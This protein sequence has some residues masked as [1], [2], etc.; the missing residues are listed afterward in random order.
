MISFRILSLTALFFVIFAI[1]P[2]ISFCQIDSNNIRI[3][4][5]QM[6]EPGGGH[7]FNYGDKNKVN[8]E[9]I[10]IGG[11]GGGRYLIP[12]G[13]TIFDFLI[14]AGGTSKR[15]VEDIKIVRFSSDTP[16]L[17]GNEVIQLSFSDFY[18]EKKD[19]L[20]SQPNP[21]LKPGDMVILPEAKDASQS[22]WFYAREVISYI[23]TFVSFY[24]LIYNIF[25]K[26]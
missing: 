17:K 19:V 2:N 23:G 14:M 4:P 8:I 25:R 18:G 26:N 6:Q 21:T 15:T 12:Q 16:R 3:G 13:T 5:E 11:G 22:F 24:Y 9:V 1:N 10:V 20:K 7:F